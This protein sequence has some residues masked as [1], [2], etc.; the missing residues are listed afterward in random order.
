MANCFYGYYSNVSY[1]S[2]RGYGDLRSE[3]AGATEAWRSNACI[4]AATR[5]L[6]RLCFFPA[7][8]HSAYRTGCFLRYPPSSLPPPTRE[9]E[10]RVGSTYI[11]LSRIFV[12]RASRIRSCGRIVRRARRPCKACWPTRSLR[13]RPRSAAQLDHAS[14]RCAHPPRVQ[15]APT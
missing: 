3:Q 5:S 12:F 15:W 6:P 1:C 14:A 8:S 11:T 7:E 4:F 2:V 9:L 10:F 13:S